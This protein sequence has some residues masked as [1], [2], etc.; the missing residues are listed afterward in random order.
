LCDHHAQAARQTAPTDEEMAA[1][2]AE[3]LNSFVFNFASTSSQLQRR[4][5][6][7]LVGLPPVRFLHPA[8]CCPASP[9]NPPAI[10]PLRGM[11]SLLLMSAADDYRHMLAKLAQPGRTICCHLRQC[12]PFV[13]LDRMLLHACHTSAETS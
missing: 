1:A 12:R 10:W 4:L 2:Q 3:T 6:Y 9:P 13:R 7:A 11:R 8:V 5:V